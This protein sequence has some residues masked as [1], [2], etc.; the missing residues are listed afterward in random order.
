MFE[1]FLCGKKFHF[2][3]SETDKINPYIRNTLNEHTNLCVNNHW[4]RAGGFRLQLQAKFV[5]H[6]ADSRHVEII[7]QF[8]RPL[9]LDILAI[10]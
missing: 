3:L 2:L 1:I 10:K 7:V 9:V 4:L 6:S 5:R 8:W